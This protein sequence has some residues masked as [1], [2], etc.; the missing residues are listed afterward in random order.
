MNRRRFA[1]VSVP[2]ALLAGCRSSTQPARDA[3]LFHNKRVRTAVADLQEAMNLLDERLTGFGPENWRDALS[4]VQ[5]AA[6][7]LRSDMD[8]LRHA[9][10]YA[11]SEPDTDRT[12]S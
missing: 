9:L 4:N 10:G 7:R 8:E 11:D 1:L 6:I 5:T 3:T 12:P 2:A